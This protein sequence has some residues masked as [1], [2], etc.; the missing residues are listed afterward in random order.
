M[1]L[2]FSSA[3]WVWDGPAAWHFV[4]TTI[5]VTRALRD[6]APLIGK[7]WGTV[8]VTVQLDGARW[9][10]SVFYDSKRQRYLLPVKTAMRK[11]LGLVAGRRLTITLEVVP[12]SP[13]L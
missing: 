7:N 8:P 6:V 1:Q 2:R 9:E 4:T 13:G 12:R 10:T 11:R 5:A 3:L